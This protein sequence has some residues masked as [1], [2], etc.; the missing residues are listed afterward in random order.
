MHNTNIDICSKALIKIGATS[1]SSFD[2]PTAEAE[3]AQNLYDIS[4][5]SLISSYPWNF[6]IKQTKLNRLNQTPV[7]DYQFSYMLPNDCL[8]IISAGSTYKSKG[9]EYRIFNNQLQSNYQDIVITYIADIIAEQL[10]VFF[11]EVLI[12]KLAAQF[13]LPLTESTSRAEFLTK[14]FEEELKKAKLLDSQQSTPKAFEDFS[15]LEARS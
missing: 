9:L 8:R 4:K 2:E 15:L 7:S 1:I 10:P 3:V 12:A 14:R 13:C 6:A 11:T 5:T